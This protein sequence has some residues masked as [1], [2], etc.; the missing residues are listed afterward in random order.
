VTAIRQGLRR[1]PMAT[2]FAL[3]FTIS[4]GGIVLLAGEVPGPTTPDTALPLALVAMF[5]GPAVAGLLTTALVSGKAG[6]RELRARLFT[7]RV[8]IRWYA[9]ALLVG[10]VAVFASL[11]VLT[12]FSRAYIPGILTTDDPLSLLL[13]ALAVALPTAFFEELGWTGF[14]TPRLRHRHGVF[15]TGVA[16]AVVW[17]VWHYLVTVWG[18]AA[19]SGTV[20]TALFLLVV[21]FSFMPA[22]R[23]LMVWVY[24]R[25]ESALIVMV[26]HASM[27]MFWLMATPGVVGTADAIAGWDM[28]AWYL[29]WA[30]LLW[31]V[32]AIVALARRR[33]GGQAPQRAP[34]GQLEGREAVPTRM[35]ST[36]G[37]S[38]G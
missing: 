9:V 27:L 13:F 34:R 16:L 28:V 38:R 20:P 10:P 1:H 19:A 23:I 29:V 36:Q 26:M 24:D 22:Y 25:T 8:S 35:P 32:V 31:V 4:W 5:A 3:T 17:G 14:A 37:A 6:L 33:T 12:P 18:S 30:A 2:Y 7:W 15:A 21:L 11:L